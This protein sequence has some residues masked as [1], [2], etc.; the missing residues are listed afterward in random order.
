MKITKTI[1]IEKELADRVLE[2]AKR[3][4]R[5]FAREAQVLI[6]ASLEHF[7]YRKPATIQEPPKQTA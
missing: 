6:E 2:L 5:N 1:I 3:E 7:G 4:W